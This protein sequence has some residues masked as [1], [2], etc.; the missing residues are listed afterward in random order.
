MLETGQTIH[1]RG[2]LGFIQPP[3]GYQNPGVSPV[4]SLE[5]GFGSK[6]GEQGA[7]DPFHLQ[8]SQGG[9]VQLG[10]AT[11]QKKDPVPG[12]YGQPFEHIGKTVGFPVQVFIGVFAGIPVS[13]DET[14]GDMITMRPPGMAGDCLMG[15]VQPCPVGE[16]VELRADCFPGKGRTA[17]IVIREIGLDRESVDVFVDDRG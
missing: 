7:D 4:Q 13:G 10:D 12:L 3:G 8:G 17:E 9:D 14:Q 16:A 6:G 2:H 1:Q 5:D 11:G 15:D